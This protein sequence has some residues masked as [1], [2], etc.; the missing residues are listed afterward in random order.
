VAFDVSLKNAGTDDFVLNLGHMLA[1]GKVMMPDA[2]R[3]TLT[4]SAGRSCELHYFDRRY[5]GVAGRMDDFIV[6][7]PAGAVFTLRLTGDRLWCA[8]EQWPEAAL[9][10]G[11][12]RVKARLEARG[13][14]TDN[15]D[16]KGVA[17]LN[18]WQVPPNP[19]GSHS[20]SGPDSARTR[21]QC[22]INMAQ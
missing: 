19:P 22:A 8:A 15:L 2:V 11:R 6:A 3:V 18:F 4:P 21:N 10:P 1:N 17:L 20:T 7:L 9:P 14:V 5:P 12:Y 16:M 13:A